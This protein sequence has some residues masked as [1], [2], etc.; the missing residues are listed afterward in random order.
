M[1]TAKYTREYKVNMGNYEHLVFGLD[2]MASTNEPEYEGLTT[3]ELSARLKAEVEEALR[4]DIIAA[5]ED[6][7]KEDSF[8][9]LHPVNQ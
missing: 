8:I 6:T 5:H 9:H 1:P 4:D 2:I 3:A 7:E